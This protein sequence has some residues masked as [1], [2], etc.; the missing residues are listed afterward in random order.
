MLV[1]LC[2]DRYFFYMFRVCL[3]STMLLLLVFFFLKQK[4]ASEMRISDWSSD[5]CSSDLLASGWFAG[6]IRAHCLLPL[7]HLA[8][9][10]PA[11]FCGGAQ[12]AVD[13]RCAPAGNRLPHCGL[14]VDR[15]GLASSAPSPGRILAAR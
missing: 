11:C 15:R 8:K 13:D 10:R 14:S 3:W 4:T 7:V 5:V 2:Y 6:R 1:L 12:E 9:P